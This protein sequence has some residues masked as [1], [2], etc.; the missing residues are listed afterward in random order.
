M[1]GGRGQDGR[2]SDQVLSRFPR[3]GRV[4]DP[5]PAAWRGRTTSR[6]SD[7]ARVRHL[8]RR[9]LSDREPPSPPSKGALRK[10]RPT[11]RDVAP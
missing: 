8:L 11:D 4:F 6:P 9:P 1:F 3:L 10:S 7:L 5:H 2:L